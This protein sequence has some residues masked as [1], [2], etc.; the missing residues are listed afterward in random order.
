MQAKLTDGWQFPRVRCQDKHADH[1][2]C[3][4]VAV[5]EDVTR[6]DA[7]AVIAVQ[8]RCEFGHGWFWFVDNGN[9]RDLDSDRVVQDDREIEQRWACRQCTDDRGRSK[10]VIWPVSTEVCPFCEQGTRYDCVDCGE[11]LCTDQLV[12]REDDGF[13]CDSCCWD[14]HTVP[15][16]EVEM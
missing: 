1:C 6:N 5:P 14:R 4:G 13:V 7:G 12:H 3:V 9:I 8:Y 10:I 2:C 16:S 15:A 11:Q